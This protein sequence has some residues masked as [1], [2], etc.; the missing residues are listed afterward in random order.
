[1][2]KPQKGR[3]ERSEGGLDWNRSGCVAAIERTK[4]INGWKNKKKSGV[5]KVETNSTS[6]ELRNTGWNVQKDRN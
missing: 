1:V 6:S 4:P 3:V 2:L 5:R